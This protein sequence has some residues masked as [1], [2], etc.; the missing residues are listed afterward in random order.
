MTIL[1][2]YLNITLNLIRLSIRADISILSRKQ[3]SWI[4][5]VWLNM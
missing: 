3:W 2:K 1:S 5:K 4:E